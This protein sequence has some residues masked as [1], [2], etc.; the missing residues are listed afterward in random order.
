MPQEGYWRIFVGNISHQIPREYKKGN[1]ADISRN[2]A[3]GRIQTTFT[4]Y[5]FAV[6]HGM[7]ENHCQC[8]KR[9]DILN[10]KFLYQGLGENM[11]IWEWRK[12]RVRIMCPA[13]A[14]SHR[15]WP[16]RC[17]DPWWKM[18]HYLSGTAQYLVW[19]N[20]ICWRYAVPWTYVSLHN[21]V[22][23][24]LQIAFAWQNLPWVHP[25]MAFLWV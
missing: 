24:C 5:Y 14:H 9:T 4:C 7:V 25:T 13:F 22:Q 6:V 8:S 12:G 17:L 18:R 10:W 21:R 1:D 2:A 20:S 19:L 3:N 16:F 15:S 23:F 11:R